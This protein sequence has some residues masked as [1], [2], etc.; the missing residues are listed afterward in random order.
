MSDGEKRLREYWQL[1]KDF[2]ASEGV[3]LYN[4]SLAQQFACY[5]FQVNFKELYDHIKLHFVLESEHKLGDF[6]NREPL[7]NFL[8]ELTRRLHNFLA[9]AKTLVDN[10]RSFVIHAY[11]KDSGLFKEY[12]DAFDRT[13]AKSAVCKFTADLRNFF[14][15]VGAPFIYSVMGGSEA[16]GRDRYTLKLDIERMSRSRPWSSGARQY[17]ETNSNNIDLELYVIDYYEKMIA[18]QQFLELRVQYWSI[19]PWNRSLEI[20]EQVTSYWA[21]NEGKRTA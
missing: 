5:T 10:T 9:S 18:F 12:R 21:N 16:R 11:G 6:N 2:Y 17:I 4:A 13:I 15:H 3:K 8:I 19:E 20:H 1:Q 14:T 7:H